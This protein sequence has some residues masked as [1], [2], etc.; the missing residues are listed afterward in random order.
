MIRYNYISGQ[1]TDLYHRAACPFPFLTVLSILTE[2]SS[3]TVVYPKVVLT[4]VFI[5]TTVVYILT[6]VS[7]LSDYSSQHITNSLTICQ[8]KAVAASLQLREGKKPN[9]ELVWRSR[10]FTERLAGEIMQY[11]ELSLWNSLVQTTTR[12]MVPITG[13]ARSFLLVFKNKIERR[14]RQNKNNRPINLPKCYNI[15]HRLQ[16]HHPILTFIIHNKYI[17]YIH[18]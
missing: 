18:T 17:I 1:T 14:G 9:T 7:S 8:R 2:V 15:L 16:V 4:V 12:K 5:P 3:P 13:R 11:I 6:V 10:P